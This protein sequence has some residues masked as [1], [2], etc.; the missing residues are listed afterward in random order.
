[1][2]IIIASI[3]TQCNRKCSYCPAQGH[4]VN[5]GQEM[6]ANVLL[7]FLDHYPNDVI[8]EI[9]GGECTLHPHLQ[10]IRA[11]INEQGKHAIIRSNTWPKSIY[12]TEQWLWATH[13]RILNDVP[14]YVIPLVFDN[15]EYEFYKKNSHIVVMEPFVRIDGTTRDQYSGYLPK[16]ASGS[17]LFL[18]TDYKDENGEWQSWVRKCAQSS[19]NICSLNDVVNGITIPP[20]LHNTLCMQCGSIKMAQHLKEHGCF[21]K[22]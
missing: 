20:A 18:A 14:Q 8:V 10:E 3:T 7:R 22:L 11:G 15:S 16:S 6:D 19:K 2:K 1:M 4:W 21:S 12:T 9:T 17:L 5:S 13:G